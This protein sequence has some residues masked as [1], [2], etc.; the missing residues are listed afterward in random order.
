MM[1]ENP[2]FPL[3]IDAGRTAGRYGKT[4]RTLDR[5]L[6]DDRLNFPKPIYIGRMRFWRVADLE[7]WEAEQARPGEGVAA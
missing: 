6:V 5:W 2:M 4:I 1:A 7:A 3:Y